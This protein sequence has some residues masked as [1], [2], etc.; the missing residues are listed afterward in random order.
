MENGARDR[1]Q[2]K[3]RKK[4]RRKSKGKR[5][6]GGIVRQKR[7]K[8][9]LPRGKKTKAKAR[10]NQGGTDLENKRR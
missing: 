3:S 5:R 10:K 8:F 4:R 2:K 6:G 7:R 1:V 9:V